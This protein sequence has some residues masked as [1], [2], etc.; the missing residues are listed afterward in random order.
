MLC[1]RNFRLPSLTRVPPTLRSWAHQHFMR[2]MM[3]RRP[4]NGTCA[5]PLLKCYTKHGKRS[6]ESEWLFLLVL[7]ERND[8]YAELN[9]WQFLFLFCFVATPWPRVT[10]NMCLR[11]SFAMHLMS[12]P[13]LT[14]IP[15]DCL[16]PI[17][18][19]SC[20]L[21]L[22][23][24][25]QNSCRHCLCG[26]ESVHICHLTL[27]MRI[28]NASSADTSCAHPDWDRRMQQ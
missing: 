12:A 10:E 15:I 17:V 26:C 28:T 16:D 24:R 1:F 3:P 25:Q 14:A 7:L 27:T 22:R 2:I 8:F 19:R 21:N 11:A 13:L 20:R 9:I 5:C 23:W 18:L 4:Q 6:C